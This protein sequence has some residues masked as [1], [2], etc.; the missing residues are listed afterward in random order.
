MA[1]QGLFKLHLCPK[2]LLSTGRSVLLKRMRDTT[3]SR[4]TT[5]LVGER[6]NVMFGS[7]MSKSVA[8]K[9]NREVIISHVQ[10][11]G[12]ASPPPVT[13]FSPK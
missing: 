13:F 4:E 8:L 12:I 9:T 5:V 3:H 7:F 2:D 1:L 6:S 11:P 10:A